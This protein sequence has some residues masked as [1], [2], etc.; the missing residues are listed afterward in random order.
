MEPR[1]VHDVTDWQG[2]TVLI[3]RYLI[4]KRCCEVDL[5]QVINNLEMG[6]QN[7][8]NP[9]VYTIGD[10]N[11]AGCIVAVFTTQCND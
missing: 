3:K 7:D 5:F 1:P 2:I 10:I 6:E 8:K 4:A 11:K 9:A